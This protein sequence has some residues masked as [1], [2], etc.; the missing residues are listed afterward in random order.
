LRRTIRSKTRCSDLA[1]LIAFH[2][3]TGLD[4]TLTAVR[5]LGRFGAT[6]IEGTR[7]KSFM[8]KPAGDG[9]HINGGFFVLQ[10]NVIDRIKGDATTWE[11]EPL[12]GLARDGQLAAYIHDGFWHPMDTLRDKQYLEQLWA[13][14]A[15]P[16]KIWA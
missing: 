7:V 6:L 2:K 13:S 11:A 8:E 5:P 9:G 16:W 10:P 12:E 4:A 14:G 15:A 1:S 3:K